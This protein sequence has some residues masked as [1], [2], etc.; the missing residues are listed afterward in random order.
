MAATN[1]TPPPKVTVAVPKSDAVS[2][3]YN[4]ASNWEQASPQ[5]LSL[6]LPPLNSSGLNSVFELDNLP[7]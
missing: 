3:G 7:L 6:S 1:A 5:L 2:K 4:F